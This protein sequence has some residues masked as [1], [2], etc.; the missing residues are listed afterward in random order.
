MKAVGR[1]RCAC[2]TKIKRSRR[3]S[4]K[5]FKYLGLYERENTRHSESLELQVILVGKP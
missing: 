2:G 3:R 4:K 1:P 5:A